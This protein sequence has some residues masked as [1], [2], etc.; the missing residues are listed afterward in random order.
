VHGGVPCGS[1]PD[2]VLA[3]DLYTSMV[4]DGEMTVADEG[5]NDVNFFIFPA[6]NPDSAALQKRIMARHETI[7]RRLKLFK[8]LKEPFRHE[9]TLHPKCFYAVANIT[10]LML[11]NGEPLF[12][13]EMH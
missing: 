2:L 12:H 7:N 11:V 8:V 10:Q 6:N 13:V 4:E 1:W 3:R 5:Y 9:L